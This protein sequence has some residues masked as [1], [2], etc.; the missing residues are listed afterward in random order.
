MAL[1][2]D[3]IDPI[4]ID[5]WRRTAID[6]AS[7]H[8]AILGL[9]KAKSRFT[10]EGGEAVH[11]PILV[12]NRTPFTET[13]YA[14]IGDRFTPTVE[15]IKAYIY[16]AKLADAEGLSND[17]FRKNSGEQAL[18]ELRKTKVPSML[19]C[20]LSQGTGSLNHKMLND[21]GTSTGWYGLPAA[22]QFDTGAGTSAKEATPTSS[23]EYAGYS[24]EQDGLS[25]TVPDADTYAHCGR[26]INVD[27]DWDSTGGAPGGFT[28]AHVPYILNYTQRKITFDPSNEEMRPDCILF[29]ENY[30]AT[31]QDYYASI[32]QW[33]VG[34]A[35]TPNVGLGQEALPYS[36]LKVYWDTDMPSN[37]G[38]MLNLNMAGYG[39]WP[40]PEVTTDDKGNITITQ[41]SKDKPKME[42]MVDVKVEQN[43]TRDGLNILATL[44]GQPWFHPRFQASIKDYS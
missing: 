18:Q 35:G 26:G 17:S 4:T 25:S 31:F 44:Y 22:L 33:N 40:N 11:Y 27:Y 2:T 32:A 1:N 39:Y 7:S 23:A 9:M 6:A 24:I 29:D 13:E 19:R 21:S 38:Y 30:W 10:K 8:K 14:Y 3:V 5:T 12:A 37:S 41:G 42:N 28:A 36:N 15:H 34:G 20:L 16:P 43:I